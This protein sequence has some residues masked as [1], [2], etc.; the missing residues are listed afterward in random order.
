[1][2]STKKNKSISEAALIKYANLAVQI[3]VNAQKNQLVIVHSDLEHA[4][5][6]RFVQKAAYKAGASNVVMDWT[7]EETTKQQLVYA[8]I[9]TIAEFPEWKILRHKAWINQG[10]AFIR[11]IS[12]TPGIY[13]TVPSNRMSLLQK[14]TRKYLNFY[15]KKTRSYEI[16]C[17]LVVVPSF[18]WVTT[19]FPTFNKEEAVSKLWGMILKGAR[20]DGEHPF[21]DWQIH[22][23]NL[24]ARKN[25]LNYQQFTQLYFSNKHGT[26]LAIGLPE[27]HQFLGGSVQDRQGTRFFPNIPTEEVFTVPHKYKING[28]LT[29]SK[30]LIYGGNIIDDFYLV[31]EKGKIIDFHASV[32]QEIL[33]N[34]IETEEGTHYLG[35]IALV[36]NDSPLA[37]MN[38]LFYNTLLDEN[39]ACHIGIGNASPA[40]LKKGIHLSE[41]ALK[42]AGLNRSSQLINVS[43]GT[44][45]LEVIGLKK[46]GTKIPLMLSGKIQF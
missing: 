41:S 10:A 31:F 40:G 9:E 28:K 1:M 23:K 27:D 11:I 20:A 7:D 24:E 8:T 30:P 29:A 43:F 2:T 14:T 18:T 17:N 33:Q 25:F 35:E 5:F 16:R 3:G 12:E 39:T 32:G 13:N 46:D 34:I 21:N 36:F 19:L 22:D 26:E 37:Q 4:E 44:K 15:Y 6:A 38:S 45:D 42:E